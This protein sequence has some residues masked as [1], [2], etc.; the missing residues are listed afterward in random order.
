MTVMMGECGPRRPRGYSAREGRWPHP[1]VG[2]HP[3]ISSGGVHKGRNGKRNSTLEAEFA[4]P[5]VLERPWSRHDRLPGV[6]AVHPRANKSFDWEL[7]NIN[8]QKPGIRGPSLS[9]PWFQHLR[10]RSSAFDLKALL[11]LSSILLP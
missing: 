3:V 9:S 8:Q 6:S 10:L 11:F 1:A 7:R 5:E 2:S 4:V